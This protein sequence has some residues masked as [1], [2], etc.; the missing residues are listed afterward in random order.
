MGRG[1]KVARPT[2]KGEYSIEFASV[3]AER[4]WRDLRAMILGPLTDSWDFLTRTPMT[5]TPTNYQ[6]KGALGTITR[7]GETHQRWQHKP[8]A[9]GDARIWFY[10]H[11]QV[12]HLEEVHTHHPNATK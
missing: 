11:N 2:K 5:V 8:T 9:Q 4:G 10:V 7:N 1:K 6:L 12:V 3:S